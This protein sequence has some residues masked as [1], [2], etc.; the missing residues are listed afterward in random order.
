MYFSDNPKRDLGISDLEAYFKEEDNDFND[1]FEADLFDF[2][3]TYYREKFSLTEV[4]VKTIDSLVKS[5][6]V[7]IQWV[8]SYYY[9]GVPSWSWY[10]LETCTI[11]VHTVKLL[12]LAATLFSVF[13]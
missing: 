5:Y 4:S 2:K 7:G 12:M 1:Q 6:V 9:T 11:H 8:L 3:A 10:E 13:L